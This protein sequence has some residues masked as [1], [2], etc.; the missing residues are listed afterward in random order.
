MK[1][2]THAH[3]GHVVKYC[4]K[5]LA[6]LFAWDVLVTGM[7][8]YLPYK[9]TI[10]SFPLPL[11][12]MVIAIY[13]SFRN[14]TA[15]SRWWEA[16]IAWGN[17]VNSSRSLTRQFCMMLSFPF[18]EQ[19][20]CLTTRH[21][22]YI[23]AL[24]MHLRSEAPWEILG[25]YLSG[26]EI[27]SLRNTTNIPNNILLRT[28][29]IIAND[30]GLDC[31]YLASID[32]TLNDIN[33]AQGIMERIKNTPLPQQYATYP[34]ILTHAFCLLLPLGLVDVLGWLTPLGSTLIS[35]LLLMLVK[36]GDE[37]QNP[38]ANTTNDI[39]LAALAQI[40]EI[41][42]LESVHIKHTLAPKSA[43]K[44]VLW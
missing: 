22:G 43:D 12:G 30:C 11:I 5:P 15:Y 27:Y 9:F 10:P 35:L 31:I 3:I 13:L 25:K 14:A 26:E 39:P 21:I 19:H 36:I 4:G 29:E 42:L 34:V 41:D 17:M 38:F 24:R 37:M 8:L 32:R 6:W 33:T 16:R 40:I 1:L 23:H 18:K 20:V 28:A 2:P 44:G 7:Y